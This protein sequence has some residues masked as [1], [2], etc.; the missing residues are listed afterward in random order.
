[1]KTVLMFIIIMMCS[2]SGGCLL[3]SILPLTSACILAFIWGVFCGIF[4]YV[5]YPNCLKPDWMD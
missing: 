4:P 5:W 3:A 1:M 2:V